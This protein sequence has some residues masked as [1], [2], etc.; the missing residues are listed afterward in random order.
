M[1]KDPRTDIPAQWGQH[2]VVMGRELH[3]RAGARKG[4]F[5]TSLLWIKRNMELDHGARKTQPEADI[6]LEN[7][8]KHAGIPERVFPWSCSTRGQMKFVVLLAEGR[9]IS[10]RAGNLCWWCNGS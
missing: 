10:S 5:Q 8:C 3:R 7:R 4:N 9:D 1:G 2:I 6:I